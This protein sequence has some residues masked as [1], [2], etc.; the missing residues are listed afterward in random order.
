[1]VYQW[2]IGSLAKVSADVAGRECE[3]LAAT[4]EGLT[5]D[6]LLE[7]SR[8]DAAPLHGCFTWDDAV[9]GE[10]YRR[11]E[12]RQIINA[13]VI[14]PETEQKEPVRAFFR[15]QDAQTF[16]PTGVILR[17]Q[18]KRAALLATALRELSAFR[19]KYQQL[20]EL[21][22]IFAAIDAKEAET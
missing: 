10:A 14:T 17:E 6:T 20:D 4:S 13:L 19:R 2:K 1:M 18:D 16:E 12:A 8:D 22:D 9:A 15:V 21:A 7:A 11:I 3:R 5:P